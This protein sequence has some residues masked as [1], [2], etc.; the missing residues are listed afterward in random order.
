[1]AMVRATRRAI[2]GRVLAAIA[3]VNPRAISA[4][5]LSSIQR[6]SCLLMRKAIVTGTVIAILEVISAATC[7]GILKATWTGNRNAVVGAWE[8][9]RGRSSAAAVFPKPR[10]AGASSLA[11]N[12]GQSWCGSG[13]V[14]IQKLDV[15][16]QEYRKPERRAENGDRPSGST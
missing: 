12:R 13:E 1:M 6:T 16:S 14:R 4:E 9:K 5:T 15:R 7:E 3:M 2:L 8:R 10:T 11:E